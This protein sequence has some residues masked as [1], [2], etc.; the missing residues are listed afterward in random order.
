MFVACGNFSFDDDDK[1]KKTRWRREDAKN[2]AGDLFKTK[3]GAIFQKKKHGMDFCL[4]AMIDGGERSR[5]APRLFV[6]TPRARGAI[7]PTAICFFRE[8]VVFI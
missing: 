4:N 2:S 8:I 7:W 6:E 1:E 5:R 3:I